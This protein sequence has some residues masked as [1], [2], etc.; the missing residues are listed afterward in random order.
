MLEEE[1][2]KDKEWKHEAVSKSKLSEL[3]AA[4]R[5]RASGQQPR[6]SLMFLGIEVYLKSP[7]RSCF[8][9]RPLFIYF[10]NHITM[11]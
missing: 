10:I 1:H 2:F 8:N 5:P 6:V 7:H 11:E 4:D 3:L 9:F